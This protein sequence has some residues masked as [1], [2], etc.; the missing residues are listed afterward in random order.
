MTR[1]QSKEMSDVCSLKNVIS[2]RAS[3]IK[4]HPIMLDRSV[5][6]RE[7]PKLMETLKDKTTLSKLEKLQALRGRYL[8]FI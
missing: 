1:R 3:K 2:R 4:C 7:K 8:V 5:T 6:G